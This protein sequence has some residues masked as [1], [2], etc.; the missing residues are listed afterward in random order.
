M[1]KAVSYSAD[2]EYYLGFDSRES[3]LARVKV[4]KRSYE[5]RVRLVQLEKQQ[6]RKSARTRNELFSFFQTAGFYHKEY[7]QWPKWA[8]T[9]LR[10]GLQEITN[11]EAETNRHR[12]AWDNQ[13]LLDTSVEK[14][15]SIRGYMKAKSQYLYS[16]AH[17]NKLQP[18]CPTQASTLLTAPALQLRFLC[19]LGWY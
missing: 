2:L 18:P 17:T 3:Y 13:V 19:Q 7:Y 15:V 10:A 9:A 11:Q 8:V 5:R 4:W 14:L 16:L 12:A 6:A 1:N